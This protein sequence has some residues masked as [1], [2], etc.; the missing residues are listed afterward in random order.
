MLKTLSGGRAKVMRATRS[1]I[2][3]LIF[4][5]SFVILWRKLLTCVL[6][7][8]RSPSVREG[9]YPQSRLPESPL[10]TRGLL[11][12][13]SFFPMNRRPVLRVEQFA[14]ERDVSAQVRIFFGGYSLPVNHEYHLGRHPTATQPRVLV[15]LRL[16]R[17]RAVAAR[18]ANH[19]HKI[20][21][22]LIDPE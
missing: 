2:R 4:W 17:L 22:F 1:S 14:V 20:K 19:A 15:E 7:S 21:I 16:L 12:R 13:T 10:L 3:N 9:T 5:K 18:R 11:T 6:V 8:V